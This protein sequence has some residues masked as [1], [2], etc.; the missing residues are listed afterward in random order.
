MDRTFVMNARGT[1]PSYHE[2]KWDQDE[3]TVPDNIVQHAATSD[4]AATATTTSVT[5]AARTAAAVPTAAGR[6]GTSFK[7]TPGPSIDVDCGRQGQS[8]VIPGQQRSPPS[9]YEGRYV[10]PS[11]SRL[12]QE[13]RRLPLPDYSRL[14]S[15]QRRDRER[16]YGA[17]GQALRNDYGDHHRSCSPIII[18]HGFLP[19]PRS[20]VERHRDVASLRTWSRS[21]HYDTGSLRLHFF[22]RLRGTL[23]PFRRDGTLTELD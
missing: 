8:P 12:R 5:T 20:V 16:T 13:R 19:P 1:I 9:D 11:S 2:T 23:G 6:L 7:H 3:P 21:P 10:T 22:Q 15:R 14:V 17:A 4:P 18:I